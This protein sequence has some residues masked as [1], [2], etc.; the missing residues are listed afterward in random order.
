MR[1]CG[2]L[3]RL[4]GRGRAGFSGVAPGLPNHWDLRLY[5]RGIYLRLRRGVEAAITLGRLAP[6][7]PGESS[8]REP[9]PGLR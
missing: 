2:G 3:L 1:G 6:S 7:W 8:P 4:T 5:H 9:A